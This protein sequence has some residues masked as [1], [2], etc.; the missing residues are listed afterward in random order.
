MIALSARDRYTREENELPLPLRI[1]VHP[2]WRPLYPFESHFLD[3]AGQKYHYLDEGDPHA[4][5]LVM[6]H[7]NPTWSFYWRNLVL[8]FRDQYRTIAPDHMGCGL[9]DKPADFPYT[10]QSHIDN[11]V[12]LWE[13]LN[14]QN[15]TLLVHDWGGAIG[16]GAALRAPQRIARLVL[17]NTGA[18]PPPFMP[19]RIRVCRTPVVGPWAMQGLNLFAR[20]AL[21][22]AVEHPESLS[23]AVKAGLLAPYDTWSNRRAI[24]RFVADIPLTRR[25]PTHAVLEEI[26]AGLPSL[27]DRPTMMIW[28]MKDWC[29]RP[30]CLERLLLS[31]PQAETDR[32]D[33]AGHYVIE[34]A[35]ERVIEDVARFLERHPLAGSPRSS[36]MPPTGDVS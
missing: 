17:F 30:E 34:D 16:L 28:G 33:D 12:A 20:A 32:I 24:A 1:P 26:E 5:P 23:P 15:I 29:F 18:F 6:V 36:A 10:L 19:L 31:F 4:E 27:N 2:D 13:K 9:S 25:H 21:S 8:A 14:L 11:L 22:M 7:G 3:L 35:T